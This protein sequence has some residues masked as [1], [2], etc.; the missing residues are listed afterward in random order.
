MAAMIAATSPTRAPS[1]A[2]A[3][4]R[5]RRGGEHGRGH[6][7]T[8]RREEALAEYDAQGPDHNHLRIERGDHQREAVTEPFAG[9]RDGGQRLRI[10]GQRGIHDIADR[11]ARI[12]PIW[13]HRPS[14]P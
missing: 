1:A 3:I 10:V 11:G 8:R 13:E 12:P 6:D 5:A 14:M 2:G 4:V 7:R 9:T